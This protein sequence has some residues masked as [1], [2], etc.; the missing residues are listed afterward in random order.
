MLEDVDVETS[1]EGVFGFYDFSD[2]FDYFYDL[3]HDDDSFEDLLLELRDGDYLLVS[4]EGRDLGGLEAIDK[5]DLLLIIG[6]LVRVGLEVLPF[7]NLLNHL[8]LRLY[9]SH[10]FLDSHY[11]FNLALL[12]HR[13]LLVG[14]NGHD[15]I[16][17]LSDNFMLGADQTPIVI[18]LDH[19]VDLN[20]DV[21]LNM[22]GPV[23]PHLHQ[24]LNRLLDEPINND[25]GNV[26]FLSRQLNRDFD[27]LDNG[28]K[29]LVDYHFGLGVDGRLVYRYCLLDYLLHFHDL[30]FHDFLSDWHLDW[31][32]DF[33]MLHNSLPDFDWLLD[34]PINDL[35]H[36][37]YNQL[38]LLNLHQFDALDNPLDHVIDQDLDRNFLVECD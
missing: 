8:H 26:G 9:L 18:E 21:V 3:R 38:L 23:L 17:N 11:L 1:D 2:V 30:G 15:L 29:F 37:D 27:L 7:H 34:I 33:L 5:L 25:R 35:R 13:V 31:D 4:G 10:H 24:N 22:H 20:R 6:Y 36:L 14:M 12:L 19:T 16:R 32:V 28:G